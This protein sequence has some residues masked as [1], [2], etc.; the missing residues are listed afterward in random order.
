MNTPTATIY[1]DAMGGDLAPG[2][3]IQG[4]VLALEACNSTVVLVGDRAQIE[5]LLEEAIKKSNLQDTAHRI[6][7]EHTTEVIAMDDHPS[8]AVRSKKNA[9]LNI[10]MRLAA[11]D[12]NSAFLSAGNSGAALASGVFHMKRLPGVERPAIA[13]SLPTRTDHR[14]L[15]VDAGAN[16]QC[17]PSQ[18]VQ[19]AL[20]GS[21][22]V[23]QLFPGREGSIG[24]LSNGE[25]DT[26]G[27]DLTRETSRILR[28]LES[29]DLIPKGIF[30]GYTEGK[31]CID[32]A[33]DVLVCDG[34]TGNILLKSLEGCV[35]TVAYILKEA[36]RTNYLAKIGM[37]LASG[38]LKKLRA[39]LD[40]SE[41]GGAPLIGLNGQAF[42]AHGGSQ[43]RAIKN[44]IL[45]ASRAVE[46]NLP[47]MLV[48]I[49]NKTKP[50]L[51]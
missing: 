41:V 44:A 15:L 18:L 30:R 12:K 3:N 16:T 36:V 28:K 25:E 50:H 27:T 5:P 51:Q 43:P 2:I 46:T 38:P 8:K 11:A 22:M 39:K 6:R 7:I 13:A 40:Y 45:Q 21:T 33:V 29:M 26:K 42:I 9:S 35:S 24:V 17:N 20:L 32:G 1:L 49:I 31:K 19:F 4:A 48:S 10:A 37:L 23:Q 34:F 14:T 47:D